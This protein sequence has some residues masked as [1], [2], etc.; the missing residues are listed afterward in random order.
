MIAGA[1]GVRWRERRSREDTALDPRPKDIG[2]AQR[3]SAADPKRRLH[4]FA[5]SP[6]HSIAHS[7]GTILIVT[8]WIV[9]VLAALVLLLARSMRIEAVCSANEASSLQAQA[10]EHGAIQ[11][12]LSHI[13]AVPGEMPTDTD[14]PCE[15]VQ[16]GDGAFWILRPNFEDDR[17]FAYG[18]VDEASKLNVNS[19]SATTL[20]YLPSVSTDLGACI[21]DWRTSATTPPS[22]GGAKNEYYSLL[23][24]PY[25]CKSAAYETMEEIFL[26]KGMT[27]DIYFGE[28]ANGNG[29]LDANEDDGGA[30]E[31]ADNQDGKLDRG[32]RTYLT[33]YSAE[34]NKDSTG[35]ARVNINSGSLASIRTLLADQ[36]SS[37]TDAIMRVIQPPAPPRGG[38]QP[39]RRAFT[40]IMDFYTQCQLL[41]LMTPANFAKIAD[42]ITTS[43]GATLKGK[44]NPG[45]APKEVLSCLGQGNN[46]LNSTDIDA[47]VAK[48]QDTSTDLTSLA[49]VAS[50]VT[51]RDKLRAIG[52]LITA[53]SYV[54]SADIVSVAAGGR[55]F[56]RC[57]VI[58]DNQ[59]GTP[60]VIYRQ[61]LTHLGWPLDPQLLDRLRSGE[62][63]QQI[64]QEATLRTEV[65]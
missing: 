26:V 1:Y 61:D 2:N 56:R 19:I 8:M 13:A 4:R 12:C 39:P 14:M 48:R 63:M 21:Y 37:T 36:T 60:K 24:A 47:I 15:A 64:S 28:D 29:V 41:G 40:S 34:P 3:I 46:W 22:V 33:I 10:I 23:P 49:W 31:P 59:S 58:I 18:L 53:R 35:K 42:K 57:R 52:N 11:Y 7:K 27:K 32:L 30:S 50:A 17:L 20:T 55:S 51:D 5:I 45:T 9:L 54:F 62:T 44:V 25:Q 6:P 38:P 65:P 16:L 43:S